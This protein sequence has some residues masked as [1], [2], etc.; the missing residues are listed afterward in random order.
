MEAKGIIASVLLVALVIGFTVW[1]EHE[2][3]IHY[4][5]QTVRAKVTDKHTGSRTVGKMVQTTYDV[6][7]QFKKYSAHIDNNQI[8]NLVEIGDTINATLVTGL[9]KNKKAVSVYLQFK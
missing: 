5:Y 2:H 7:I 9:D 8:Y 4:E 6:D 3:P 1:Y